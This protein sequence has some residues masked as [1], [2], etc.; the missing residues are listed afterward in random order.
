M[1]KKTFIFSLLAV[2]TLWSLQAQTAFEDCKKIVGVGFHGGFA[3]MGDNTTANNSPSGSIGVNATF[4]YSITRSIAI[5]AGAD[6]NFG[7][8]FLRDKNISTYTSEPITISN[9]IHGD[10]VRTTA[11]KYSFNSISEHYDVYYIGIPL[12]V[13]LQGNAFDFSI[14]QFHQSFF[15]IGAKFALPIKFSGI[16]TTSP[17]Q[18][19]IG[20][21]V[22]GTGV[23]LSEP[24]PAGTINGQSVEY[25]VKQYM[26]SSFMIMLMAEAGTM[27][28]TN[29]HGALTFSVF[30][31]Y[32]L[33]PTQMGSEQGM[34]TFDNGKIVNNGYLASNLA[35][36]MR[37]FQ[38]GIR[39]QYN[40]L[41]N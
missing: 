41:L 26:G 23:T 11:V 10:M 39:L 6:F 30:I 20:P 12:Q 27:L 34:L 4:S 19:F 15:S 33:L 7:R 21:D 9:D 14:S 24:V 1:K 40:F 18:R 31:E 25:D 8:S 32:S 29:E 38:G 13:V 35:D 36:K 17:A 2:C 22:E 16:G 5:K 3:S 37:Y 28:K